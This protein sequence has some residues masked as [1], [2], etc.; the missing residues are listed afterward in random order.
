MPNLHFDNYLLYQLAMTSHV[1]SKDFHDEL[2]ELGVSAVDW[3]ILY[4]LWSSPG[5]RLTELAKH[6]LYKQPRVTKRVAVLQR[7]SLVKKTVK[8]DDRRNIYLRLTPKG[9]SLVKPLIEKAHAHEQKILS[10][11][12]ESEIMK[13]RKTLLKLMQSLDDA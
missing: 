13:F 4:C 6:V 7:E 2:K 12:S 10:V 3:R 9:Q 5:I 8:T 11:L 1:I